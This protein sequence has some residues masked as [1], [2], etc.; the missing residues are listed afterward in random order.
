MEEEEFERLALAETN[1]LA[2][3][4]EFMGLDRLKLRLPG[5]PAAGPDPLSEERS[6]AAAMAAFCAL[7]EVGRAGD[8]PW[9]S[10]APGAV[11]FVAHGLEARRSEAMLE[12]ARRAVAGRGLYGTEFERRDR[13]PELWV[14]RSFGRGAEGGRIV[15]SVRA[16]LHRAADGTCAYWCSATAVGS[17]DRG[18]AERIFRSHLTGWARGLP[19]A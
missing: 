13:S 16:S 11:R 4:G 5:G 8:R 19:Q 3:L 12:A 7:A 15:S 6:V 10:F 2:F 18:R 14:V 9:I 1:Y 17:F